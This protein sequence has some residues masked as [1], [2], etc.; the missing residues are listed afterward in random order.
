MKEYND[1]IIELKSDEE[2]AYTNEED[3]FKNEDTDK[4]LEP[5]TEVIEKRAEKYKKKSL[6]EKWQSL[7]PKKKKTIII[8]AIIVLLILIGVIICLIL[9]NK[10]DGNKLPENDK[11]VVIE[12]DNYKYV[13]GHL[14]FLDKNDQEI[15]TYEC[16]NKNSDDCAVSKLDN[17]KDGFDR[18]KN[19]NSEGLEIEKNSKIYYDNYVFVRD[20]DDKFLYDI[21]KKERLIELKTVK[22]YN[23]TDNLIVIENTLGQYGLIKINENGYTYQIEAKYDNL[24][25]VNESLVYLVAKDSN[26]T[27]IVDSDDKKISTNIKAEIKSVNKEFIVGKMNNAY[28]LYTYE[29]EEVISDYDY[30]S[31]HDD[32]IGLVKSN[33]LY[34][35]DNNLNKLNEDGIRLESTN[36]LVAQNVYDNNKLVEVK[37]SYDIEVRNNN[38]TI[39]TGDTVKSLNMLEGIVSSNYEYLSYYDGKLY[40][41][42]DN[43]KEDVIGVYNCNNQNVLNSTS[44]TLSKC[45]IYTVNGKMSGIYNN[46]YVFIYDN[47][48]NADTKI[49]LYDLK[50]NKN[51]SIYTS[52]EI[53]NGNEL[54]SDV[55]NIYTSSSYVIAKASTGE[56]TGNY[57]VLEINSNNVKGIV[58]FKY[59]EIKKKR[60]YYLLINIDDSYSIYDESF[61]KVSNEFDYI[62][63]YDNYFVGI[64]D[65]KLNVYSYNNKQGILKSS[66]EVSNNEFAIDFSDGF[67]ITINGITYSF[68]LEGND[69]NEE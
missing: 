25:I 55:K 36:Y 4:N 53:L 48:S 14:V 60:N 31:L 23:T 30:I 22:A 61:N 21:N 34:V 37:K 44:D 65:N 24:G 57:G 7:E 47:I 46:E 69:K 11:I 62:E 56:N 40:F 29:N 51:K 54:N 27:F 16:T 59:K 50:T 41:Y 42:S 67:N 13:N 19:V 63:V 8:V 49:Y 18:I 20:G 43:D 15:G 64:T 33:R 3:L 58:E 35:F 10:K 66:L 17:K 32:V 6:K 39:T 28:N 52:V 12:K 2:V 68:D 5:K 1:E 26:N 45:N 9:F 38:I